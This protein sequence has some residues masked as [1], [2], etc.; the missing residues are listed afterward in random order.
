VP[1]IDV[2]AW[3]AVYAPAGTPSEIV[4]MLQGAIAK[5]LKDGP[6]RDKLAKLNAQVVASTPDAL[7]K[8]T[9]QELSRWGR[10]IKLANIKSD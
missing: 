8:H 5:G 10:I 4:S 1:G 3:Y 7:S 6:A 9:A 2:T